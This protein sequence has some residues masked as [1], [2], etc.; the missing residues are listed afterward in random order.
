MA[1][2][3][4]HHLALSNNEPLPSLADFIARAGS[5]LIIEFVPKDDP[6]ARKLL[7]SRDD[8]FEFYDQQNFERA[9]GERFEI[10]QSAQLPDSRRRMYLMQRRV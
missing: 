5:W 7:A 3:L 2:A 9:F 4:I 1:L 10:R 8:I 6:Q